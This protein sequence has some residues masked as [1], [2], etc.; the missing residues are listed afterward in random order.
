MTTTAPA[1]I[2][3]PVCESHGEMLHHDIR[4]PLVYSCSNCL[5]EWEIQSADV[6]ADDAV[7]TFL[8]DARQSRVVVRLGKDET[9]SAVAGREC[10]KPNDGRTPRS[11]PGGE[12]G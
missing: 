3:C 7:V 11:T 6:A 4:A 10:S 1:I 2:K 12:R 8:A 9:A 5:H